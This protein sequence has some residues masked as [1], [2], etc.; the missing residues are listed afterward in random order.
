MKYET[1]EV[2]RE[3]N[4]VTIFNE[5]NSS[6]KPYDDVIP[7][8]NQLKELNYKLGIITDLGMIT[9]SILYHISCL[10]MLFL[11][12]NHDPFML[13]NGPYPLYVIQRIRSRVG[14]LS[15]DQALNLFNH[16]HYNGRLKYLVLGHLSEKNNDRQIVRDIFEK[17]VN[18][19]LLSC[20]VEIASQD[21][22][23]KIINL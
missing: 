16:L 10:D 13:L 14:H 15:N 5:Y 4:I 21:K 22:P 19:K 3:K 17:A 18:K 9:Q 23:G 6:L 11:E 12:S 20:K 2:Q 8:L 1:L 7:T